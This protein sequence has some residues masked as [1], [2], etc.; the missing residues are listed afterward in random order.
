M[1]GSRQTPEPVVVP[2]Q[3]AMLVS[4][5]APSGWF[6]SSLMSTVTT[7]ISVPPR[8]SRAGLD[9]GVAGRTAMTALEGEE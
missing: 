1:I 9:V 5:T 8:C 2:G 7:T 6:G 3:V 4:H